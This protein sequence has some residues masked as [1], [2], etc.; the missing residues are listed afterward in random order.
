MG[1][2]ALLFDIPPLF[3]AFS[4][5]FVLFSVPK[6]VMHPGVEST[7]DTI[8]STLLTCGGARTGHEIRKCLAGIAGFGQERV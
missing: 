4:L 8:P 6:V 2:F 1:I 3:F 7:R 5:L